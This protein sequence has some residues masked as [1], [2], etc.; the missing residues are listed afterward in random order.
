[1]PMRLIADRSERLDHFLARSMPEHSRSKLAKIARQDSVRVNGVPRYPSYE[2]SPGNIVELEAPAQTA[3]HDLTPANIP[4]D[5]RYED[6]HLLV[7]NK[8]RG[9]A[10]HPAASLQAPSLVNALLARKHELSSAA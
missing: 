5:V 8:P 4:L 9:L 7:I 1:M 6:E 10:V 3:P 2:L